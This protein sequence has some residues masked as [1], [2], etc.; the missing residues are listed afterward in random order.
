MKTVQCIMRQT[1]T[2]GIKSLESKKDKIFA[3][4]C[5]ADLNLAKTMYKILNRS[6]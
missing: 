2:I 4:L 3:S 5:I 6:K 1:G